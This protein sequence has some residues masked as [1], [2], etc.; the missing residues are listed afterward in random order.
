MIKSLDL[1]PSGTKREREGDDGAPT[2]SAEK[3]LRAERERQVDAEASK[4]HLFYG[5][6]G[7]LHEELRRLRM[8]FAN[9]ED[10]N[11]KRYRIFDDDT[12]DDI[13]TKLPS[14]E[15]QLMAC[16]G[17]AR[18]RCDKYGQVILDVVAKHKGE[19]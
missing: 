2:S 14:D 19:D 15:Y 4:R 8:K 18:K 6:R 10:V 16:K 5:K 11:L 1:P 12:L 7:G 3:K 9:E 17:I 13:V